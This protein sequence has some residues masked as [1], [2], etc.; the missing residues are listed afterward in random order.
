MSRFKEKVVVVTGAAGGIGK[1]LVR[2]VYQEGASVVLVDLNEKAL[3]EAVKDLGLEESRYLTV[4]ANVSKEDQVKNYVDKTVEKFGRIDGFF[5]NA[6]VEG[7]TANIEDYD[8]STFEFVYDVNVKGVFLGMKYVVPVMKKQGSGSI[9][10]AGSQAGLVGT[11][12]MSAYNSSKHAVLGLTKVVAAEVAPFG[13]RVN[14]TAP[15]GVNTSMVKRIEQN[16]VPD[17]AEEA[18]KLFTS[19][20]PM[21]RYGEP[22]EIASVAAFLLS[23]DSSYVTASIYTIDG[24]VF[25]Q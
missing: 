19:A 18:N 7:K 4:A 22:Q 6:G 10:N 8:L 15:G 1:E 3:G 11:P 17:A 21:G 2:R 20:I 14:A 9:V 13:I 12:G 16:T 24:G 5:N 23:D 25:P